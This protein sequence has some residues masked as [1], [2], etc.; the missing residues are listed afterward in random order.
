MVFKY[1][2]YILNKPLIG[3]GR[4]AVILHKNM[5]WSD[6]PYF[7]LTGLRS[8]TQLEGLWAQ[9]RQLTFHSGGCQS[10]PS[11]QGV[12]WWPVV[13]RGSILMGREHKHNLE[14]GILVGSSEPFPFCTLIGNMF[15]WPSLLSQGLSPELSTSLFQSVR[16]ATLDRNG[17][18]TSSCVWA[19]QLPLQISQPREQRITFRTDTQTPSPSSG[20]VAAQC[21]WQNASTLSKILCQGGYCCFCFS[22]SVTTFPVNSSAAASASQASSPL[23]V[24]RSGGAGNTPTLKIFN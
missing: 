21:K 24:W 15:W 20:W 2:P 13:S 11:Q 3:I 5:Q 1:P 16:D 12:G 18:S 10:F 17:G 22:F 6:V 23:P 4:S 19:E 14:W 7:M 9:L 8:L